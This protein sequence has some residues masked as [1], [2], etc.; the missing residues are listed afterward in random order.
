M[1]RGV[2]EHIY[3][4]LDDEQLLACC[5]LWARI[6]VRPGRTAEALAARERRRQ[7]T[8]AWRDRDERL[9]RVDDDAGQP[10]ALARSFRR[11]VGTSRGS[12]S[13]LALASVCSDPA[14][15]GEGLGA[16]VVRAAFARVGGP[17]PL[18]LFQTDVG[19]FYEGLGARLISNPC[20]NRST[21]ERAFWG[22]Q[23]MI[24]PAAADLPPDEIDLRGTGW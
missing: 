18:S 13:I 6:F 8:C 5:R 10:I 24:W 12:L 19:A 11:T 23:V 9:H 1:S 20:V 21:R 14:R 22:S 7:A 16:A 4:A 3:A 2:S 17:T 15:R